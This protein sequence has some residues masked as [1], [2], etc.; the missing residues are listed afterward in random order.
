MYNFTG[1]DT[2]SLPKSLGIAGRIPSIAFKIPDLE[3]FAQ[4]TL[5]EVRTGSIKACVQATLSNG[6]STHQPAVEWLTGAFAIGALLLAVWLS[7]SPE[8]LVPF[9][10]L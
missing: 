9:L 7:F 4:L 3:G 2:I 10:F 1:A 8:A 6:W 5:T